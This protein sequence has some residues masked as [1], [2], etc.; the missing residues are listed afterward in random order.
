MKKS[1]AITAATWS[2]SWQ[3]KIGVL[4]AQPLWRHLM[5][6]CWYARGDHSICSSACEFNYRMNMRCVPK[7]QMRIHLCGRYEWKCWQPSMLPHLPHVTSNSLRLSRRCC[8]CAIPIITMATGQLKKIIM[9]ANNYQTVNTGAWRSSIDRLTPLLA[10]ERRAIGNSSEQWGLEQLVKRWKSINEL[11]INKLSESSSAID[12]AN[13]VAQ[14]Q[15]NERL[16]IVLFVNNPFCRS[17][18]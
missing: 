13:R 6:G 5:N 4:S 7:K 12:S 18:G 8:G 16:T 10:T 3:A 2:L 1:C 11:R 9:L 15:A 14:K 17:S